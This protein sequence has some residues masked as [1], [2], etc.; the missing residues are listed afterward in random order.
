MTKKEAT[1]LAKALKHHGFDPSVIGLD[2]HGPKP[3]NYAIRFA[4]DYGGMKP[5]WEYRSREQIYDN[6]KNLWVWRSEYASA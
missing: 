2:L 5:N 1:C 4:N 6:L 3:T